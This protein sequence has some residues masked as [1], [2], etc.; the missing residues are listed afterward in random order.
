MKTRGCIGY[1]AAAISALVIVA[2][3]VSWSGC[4]K[5]EPGGVKLAAIVFQE[6]QFFR[7][8]LFGMR[9]AAGKAGV[10]LLEGN[11]NNK[12]DKE[13]E[14]VKTY[15]ARKVSAILISPLSKTGSVAAV[16][17]AHDK[18][19]TIVAHNTPLDADFP[20]AYIECDPTDLGRQTGLAARR[21]I[22]EKL[23]GKAKIA[24]LAFKSQVPEQSNARVGGFLSE[25]RQLPGVEIVAEQDAWLPEMAIAK[26]G[27][28][29]TANPGVDILYAANEGGTVGAV[30]A[31]KKAEKAGKVAVFGTDASEQLI[32]FLESSDNILQAIT[33]QRPVEVGRMAVEFALKALKG[34][35]VPPK[36][37]LKGICL[38]RGD[39]E[40]VKAYGRQLKEWMQGGG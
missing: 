12:L 20:V 26:A 38:W 11:S 1:W 18:G 10:E 29:L 22:Q 32:S 25:V 24:I 31:V 37:Y 13:I 21:Y 23:G 2:A 35:P 19:I 39:P 9:D 16:K 5:S 27:D 30:L 7:L 40:G 34:E 3:A 4:R 28:I 36:T 15:V 6:D 33:A 8:V 14:L 17:L